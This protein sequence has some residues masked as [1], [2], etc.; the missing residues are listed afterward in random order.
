MQYKQTKKALPEIARELNVNGIV[1]GTV[2][3]SG[4][5][6]RITAQLIYGPSDKHLWANSYERDLHDVFALERDLTEEIAREVRAR[7]TTPNQAPVAPPRSVNPAALDAYLQG[8][9]HLNRFARGAGDQ[10]KKKA[11]E[12]FQRAIE[13]DPDFAHAYNGLAAAH[14]N[15][16]WPSRQ[17]ADIATKA[18]EHAVALDPN[19]SDAHKILANI[20]LAGWN[21]LRAEQ[22]FRRAVALS[23]NSADAHGGLGILLDM[24][25]RLDEGW[26]EERI[27]QEL[28]PNNAYLFTSS[29]LCDLELRGDYDR[30]ITIAQTFLKVHPD[31][32]YLHLDLAEDYLKKGM[33]EEAMPHMEQFWT[34]FGR[35]EVSLEVHRAF[36][37]S[38]YRAAIQA[39]A[40][41]TEHL[42][43]THQLF[44]PVNLAEL[45]ATVGDKE[46]AFYWLEQ[47]Y[48][49]RDISIASAG[50]GLE[51]LNM[52]PLLEPL[53]S[54]PR[55]KDLV[56]RV[57]LPEGGS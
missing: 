38:G 13:A 49:Q 32:G 23:P 19:S 1:E 47:A 53:R 35:P 33:Y 25:G 27:A 41:A 51:W 55:F 43:A 56:H 14:L 44:A 22:E 17:D 30:A 5:R 21:W 39:S 31:D 46:R 18:A 2:Q 15:L 37:T 29:V 40:K 50:L 48:V 34:L 45:Y 54:D 52:E 20:K 26:K 36:V 42:M 9:Y 7:L 4:D 57:G 3:R 8:N 10:V 11:A 28:D 12:Y 16:L 6:V 24:T